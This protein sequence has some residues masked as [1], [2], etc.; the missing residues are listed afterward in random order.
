MS[1]GVNTDSQSNIIPHSVYGNTTDVTDRMSGPGQE[2]VET[3]MFG[4]SP[5]LNYNAY[6]ATAMWPQQGQLVNFASFLKSISTASLT[7]SFTLKTPIAGDPYIIPPNSGMRLIRIKA[8]GTTVNNADTKSVNADVSD[9]TNTYTVTL[10]LTASLAGKWAFDCDIL[11]ISN[12][13]GTAGQ[14]GAYIN[15]C[16]GDQTTGYLPLTSSS[17]ALISTNNI[18]FGFSLGQTTTA[19]DIVCDSMYQVLY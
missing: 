13:G 18:S 1:I 6:L 17:G 8:N 2:W 10:T 7:T 12:Y 11:L 15:A 16:G 5:I 4:H 19:A 9:G 3:P 14:Y